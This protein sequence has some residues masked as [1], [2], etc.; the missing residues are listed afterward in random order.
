MFGLVLYNVIPTAEG[1]TD[2]SVFS[3]SYW[4]NYGH[5]L[6]CEWRCSSCSQNVTLIPLDDAANNNND[7]DAVDNND[8]DAVD[9]NDDD[10]VD[11]NDDDAADNNDD[12]A[13]DNN[14]DDA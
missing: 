8:D 3:T 5:S 11:N 12:D 13:A 4:Y 9:N 7:D 2:Q 14:D 10:A 6:F 1:D